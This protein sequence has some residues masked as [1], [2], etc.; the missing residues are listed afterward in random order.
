VTPGAQGLKPVLDVA[1]PV[2]LFLVMTIVGLDLTR[3][4]FERVRARPRVLVA[5]LAGPLL[6]LPPAAL[7]VV[8]LVPMPVEIREGLLLLAVCPVGGIS[9][10]YN[11]LARASTALSVTLTAASC[12]LAV[13][14]MPVL[15]RLFEAALGRPLGFHAPVGPLAV[16]ILGML[17]LPV[18]AGMALRSRA[19]EFAA[20]HEG[21]FRRAAFGGLA[22]LLGFILWK[23]WSRFVA[24]LAATAGAAL[25]FVLLA[26]G[27]GL[28]VALAA[29]ADRRERFTLS[30]EFATRNNAIAAAVAITLLGD[31]RFAVFATTYFFTESA[32]ILAAVWAFRRTNAGAR[33]SS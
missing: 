19:P 9:N 31:T 5:G 17:V 13:A 33:R 24:N 16:Q 30:V 18:A 1:I 2:V 11:Y 8:A 14:T 29:G 4:D 12:L 20:R 25:L 21:A 28:L 3:A 10:T 32:P 23:E 22:V 6:L 26:M 15:T 7:L 27:A